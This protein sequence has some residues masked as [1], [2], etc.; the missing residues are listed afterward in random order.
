[1]EIDG[2]TVTDIL[3]KRLKKTGIPIILTVPDT[4]E[5]K[6]YLEPIAERNAVGFFMGD[7]DSPVKRHIQA[8]KEFDVDYIILAEGDDWL[9]CRETVNAVY[10]RAKELKF[11][12]AIRTEGLPFGMNVIAYPR[13][14]LENAGFTGDTGWGAYVTKGADV[15][16]FNY[17][18]PYK[19]SM[20]YLEDFE[21]MKDVYLNCKRNQYVG[22]IVSYMDKR[23]KAGRG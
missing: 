8:C 3:I 18:R 17:A 5:D 16:E 6:A 1:V 12:K 9:V 13:E 7:A 14:N 15:L 10:Y 21:T 20:D 22:G 11:K 23:I 2:E 4:P 19:L